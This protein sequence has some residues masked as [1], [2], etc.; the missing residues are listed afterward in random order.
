MTDHTQTLVT[1]GLSDKDLA[2]LRRQLGPHHWLYVRLRLAWRKANDGR[3]F[4]RGNTEQ[5]V[6]TIHRDTVDVE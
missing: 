3:T 1:L 6:R 5:R 2:R 4:L